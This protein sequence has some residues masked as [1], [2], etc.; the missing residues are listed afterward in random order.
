MLFKKL[1]FQFI[2]DGSEYF[3]NHISTIENAGTVGSSRLTF[4]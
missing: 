1:F 2:N 4:Q 3:S